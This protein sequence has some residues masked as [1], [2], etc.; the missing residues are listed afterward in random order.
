MCY[1]IINVQRKDS[2]K[3]QTLLQETEKDFNLKCTALRA[4]DE[5]ES[6]TTFIR[7]SKFVRQ[8]KWDETNYGTKP[9]S[10]PASVEDTAI[11]AS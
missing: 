1:G 5:V 8:I 7:G 3:V 2:K 4:D 10:E 11:A 6:F 9:V